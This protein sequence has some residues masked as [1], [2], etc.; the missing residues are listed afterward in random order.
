MI[1]R[2]Q[3]GRMEG[4]E[5]GNGKDE[6]FRGDVRVCQCRCQCASVPVG[7]YVPRVRVKT[8]ERE[9]EGRGECGIVHVC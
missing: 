7:V 9:E 2:R 6:E 3:D 4:W 8:V 5:M 1:I